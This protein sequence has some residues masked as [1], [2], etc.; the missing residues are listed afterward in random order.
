MRSSGTL[1]WLLRNPK[2]L[3]LVASMSQ[4]LTAV[5][6]SRRTS[7]SLD[8]CCHLFGDLREQGLAACLNR[9]SRR[10]RL[11]WLTDDGM[12]C[13]GRLRKRS[14]LRSLRHEFPAVAWTLYGD[15]CFSHRAA[16]I[17]ALSEP[18]G[19]AAIRRRARHRSPDL[20]MSGSNT[21]GALSDLRRRGVVRTV[22]F[23]DERWSRFD[24]TPTGK[25]IRALLLG[26]ER[27]QIEPSLAPRV[28]ATEGAP[29]L[30]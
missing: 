9:D 13:Q 26:A 22:H 17:T 11:F 4:P 5:Q 8:A 3:T 19:A 1:A 20:R 6:V 10:Y 21:R 2:R 29:T 23:D 24:L 28:R 12:S 25:K 15:M 7:W 16:I 27:F 30:A 14:G 18:L